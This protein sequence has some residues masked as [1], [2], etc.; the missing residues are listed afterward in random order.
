[1]ESQFER[2]VMAMRETLIGLS[3]SGAVPAA[4]YFRAKDAFRLVL[5]KLRAPSLAY[6][7]LNMDQPDYL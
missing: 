4:E 2:M 7:M 6:T 3:D 1:M 5:I